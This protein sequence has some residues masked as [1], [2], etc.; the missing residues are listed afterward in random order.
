MTV[1]VVPQSPAPSLQSATT[2]VDV[3]AATAPTSGQ[4]L[5][6]TGESAATWQ[7]P[8]GPPAPSLTTITNTDSPYTL[9]AADTDV[10]CDT[11][12]G[13]ITVNLPAS[14]TGLRT[15]KLIRAGGSNVTI[16][17]NAAET[18]GANQGGG[19]TY[20]LITD[21]DVAW[22]EDIGVAGDEWVL[23]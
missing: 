3:A 6:A 5:T 16:D 14:T 1:A 10:Y 4:I 22:L 12:G 15:V 19:T 18:V 17:G 8:A 2:T 23:I 11:S 13:A 7:A 9:L 20:T 21:G